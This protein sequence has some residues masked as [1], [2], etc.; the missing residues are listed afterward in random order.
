MNSSKQEQLK[1]IK[2]RI[3]KEHQKV[4][5]KCDEVLLLCQPKTVAVKG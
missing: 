4:M 5:D 3:D 1:A 2:E